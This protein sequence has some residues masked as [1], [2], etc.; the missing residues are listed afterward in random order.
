MRLISYNTPGGPRVAGL[1]NEHFIDLNRAD[2][3]LP[4]CIKA[5]LALG[6]EGIR[7]AESALA[8]GEPIP[9]EQIQSSPPIPKPEK[10]ICVGLNYADHAKE[11]GAKNPSEPILFCKFTTAACGHRQPVVLPGASR[12]V[13]FEA[14]L[15]VVIGRG[16][17]HIPRQEAMRHVAGYCCGNDVSARD[18]QL[19][20]P[21]GQWLLG[22]SF[23]TFAP[24][25]PAIVT[26]DEIHEPHNLSI[27]LRL[28]GQVMQKSNTAQL[29]FP[30]DHLI[31]YV[32]DVCT[33]APGD[34]IFT[35]TP[36]GVGFAR[37]PPVFL[38]SGDVMEVE[39]EKIGVLQNPIVS[40]QWKAI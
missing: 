16:G 24:F 34:L 15:V 2:P 14:E 4:Q 23:D 1:R 31:A 27:E 30:I 18:W 38:K 32:S 29:I 20:K 5:L 11:T 3:G 10:I 13:D 8:A 26:A 22:K 33:L 9:P 40:E 17:R 35:G 6:P 12:E 36:P 21:G 25:G 37:K 19:R 28:N 7:R 39:I